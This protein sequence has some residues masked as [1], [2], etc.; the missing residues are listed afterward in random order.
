W[1]K[2]HTSI[3]LNVTQDLERAKKV[4]DEVNVIDDKKF[5]FEDFKTL[6]DKILKLIPREEIVETDYLHTIQNMALLGLTENISLSNGVFEVKRRKILEMDKVGAF[7][8]LATK[9][10]F[11]KYYATTSSHHYSVWTKE[12]RDAYLQEITNCVTLYKPFNAEVD[13][14]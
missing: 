13:E 1:L 12:E 10:V 14:E 5:R 2:S 3:L 7:I 8:P 4:I 11:L 9:R 6:S